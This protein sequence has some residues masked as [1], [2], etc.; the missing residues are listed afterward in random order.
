MADPK[1]LRTRV[2]V[3]GYNFYYGCLKR[4]NFKWLDLKSLFDSL[5]KTVFLEIDGLSAQFELQTPAI[6]KRTNL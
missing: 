3:D 5:L 4:T 1:I 6:S 2:Y